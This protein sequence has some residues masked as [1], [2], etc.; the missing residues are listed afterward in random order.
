[1]NDIRELYFLLTENPALFD[2]L[3]DS[4]S[5]YEDSPQ[6]LGYIGWIEFSSLP[7]E[8]YRSALFG[9]APGE[10]APPFE[11]EEGFHILKVIDIKEGGMPTLEEY[12]PQIETMAL[13]QKQADYLSSWLENKRKEVF[14]KTFL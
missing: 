8:S 4:L 10:I 5:V 6:D 12:Y 1:L 11:T 13:R 3:V 14:I 2:S 7:A 9:S